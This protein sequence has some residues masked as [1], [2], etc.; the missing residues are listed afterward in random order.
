VLRQAERGG[1]VGIPDQVARTVPGEKL[2][3]G[4]RVFRVGIELHR[5]LGAMLGEVAV[6]VRRLLFVLRRIGMIGGRLGELVLEEIAETGYLEAAG[7]DVGA[8][9]LADG[10]VVGLRF[11]MLIRRSPR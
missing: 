8:V 10:F 5:R 6:P 2:F 7:D 11:V 4:V 1:L 3:M 9:G